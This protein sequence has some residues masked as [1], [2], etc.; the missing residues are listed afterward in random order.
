MG[1]QDQYLEQIQHLKFIVRDLLLQHYADREFLSGV[2]WFN[3][4]S[5]ILPLVLWYILS[6]K[7]RLMELIIVGLTTNVCAGFLDV[8][9]SEFMLWDYPT[10]VFPIV[11]LLVPIDY[12]ILPV[13][14][15]LL[16]QWFP[17]WKGFLIASVIAAAFQSFVAE[18]LAVWIGQYQLLSW[19]YIYSFPIYIIIGVIT[20]FFTECVMARQM[21]SRGGSS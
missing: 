11:P 9:G 7:K 2:W 18:P 20:K 12:V 19:K 17:N 1:A 14:Q 16:Y 13:I 10:H 21:K 15:M 6:D 3:I 5:L 8:L 4:V